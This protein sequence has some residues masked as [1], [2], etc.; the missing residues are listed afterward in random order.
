MLTLLSYFLLFCGYALGAGL[1]ARL[2]RRM[3]TDSD[4]TAFMLGSLGWPVTYLI[5]IPVVI[6]SV[7]A[8]NTSLI[9]RLSPRHRSQQNEFREEIARWRALRRTLTELLEEDPKVAVDLVDM[10]LLS[11]GD[12]KIK[13]FYPYSVEVFLNLPTHLTGLVDTPVFLGRVHMPPVDDE[14]DPKFQELIRAVYNHTEHQIL[15]AIT[16]GKHD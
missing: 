9:E 16:G 7:A 10:G 12:A 14:T 2:L 13:R 5:G 4:D 1:T 6:A 3:G 8:G 11:T 15:P